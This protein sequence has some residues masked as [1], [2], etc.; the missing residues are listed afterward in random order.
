MP[1]AG[2]HYRKFI[3]KLAHALMQFGA[4]MHKIDEQL[5]AASEFFGLESQF[6]LLNTVIIV[7][8]KGSNG[9]PSRTHFIQQAQGLSL[10]Q[11]RKTHVIYSAVI[12]DEISAIEGTYQLNYI[13]NLSSPFSKFWK[14]V[15]AFLAGAAIAPLGFSGS[16]ADSLIA[17]SLSAILQGVQ[18]FGEGDTLFIGIFEW[19]AFFTV[20]PVYIL[21]S[22]SVYVTR[23]AIA[24]FVSLV[25]RLLNSISGHIFC[26]SA[27]SSS[28][29]VLILPGFLVR[30]YSQ[31]NEC[32]VHLLICF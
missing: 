30:K 22:L 32:V 3:L 10:A 18:L 4:P 27:I 9:S 7:V 29:V 15:F 8:F 26:Y 19:V 1:K 12:H 14:I 23:M 25:A 5:S 21:N 28:G 2:H 20:S 13:T 11:L 31:S 24:I 17:G 6:I 16:F